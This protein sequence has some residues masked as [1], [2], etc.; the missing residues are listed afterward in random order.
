M[1]VPRLALPARLLF[2]GN[3]LPA[4]QFSILETQ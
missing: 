1:T 2:S 3:R 4:T